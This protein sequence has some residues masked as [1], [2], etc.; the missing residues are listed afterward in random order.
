MSEVLSGSCLCGKKKFSVHLDNND[1]YYCHCNMCKKAFGNIFATFTNV[2]AEDVIWETEK[3]DYF[4][5]SRYAKRGF[6]SHCGTPMTFQYDDSIYMDLAVGCF[7]S[8]DYFELRRHSGYE[9]KIH[10]LGE[11]NLPK[12]FTSGMED[13]KEKWQEIHANENNL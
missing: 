5:S 2:K 11:D 10:W 6:C 3:P 1:A 7:D 4:Q 9:S 13:P 8:P 12:S